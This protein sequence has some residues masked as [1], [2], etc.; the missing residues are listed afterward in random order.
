MHIQGRLKSVWANPCRPPWKPKFITSKSVLISSGSPAV[1]QLKANKQ[2]MTVGE[3]NPNKPNKIILFVGETGAGKSTLIDTLLNYTMGVKFEDEV[4]FQILEEEKR[5]QTESQTPDVIVYEIFDFENKTL[6]YSLT[7][8]DTPGY[9]DTR[10]IEH[11]KFINQRLLD[12]FRSEDGVHELHTVGL[13][14][15]ASDNRLSDRLMYVYDSVVSLFGENME[16]NIVAL[17]THSTGGP[18]ENVLHA[19][20]AA[21]VKCAKNEKQQPVHFLFDNCQHKPRNEETKDNLRCSWDLTEKGIGQF[22]RFLERSRHQRLMKTLKVLKK[23]I[24]LTACIQNLQERIKLTE[25]KQ[26]E[27]RQIQDALKKHDDEMKRNE[28]FTVEIDEVSK[29]KEAIDGGMWGVVFFEGAVCCTVCK[30]NCHYPGCTLAWK[31]EHCEVIKKGQCTSCTKKCP[32]SDHVKENWRYVTK[33]IKVQITKEEMKDKYDRNKSE[34]E[35]KSSL[36]E[37]LENEMENL[38]AEKKRLLDEAYKNVVKLELIALKVD[39]L[40]TIVHLDF[41]IE[42]VKE[43]RDTEKVQKLEEMRSR[44]DEG[45]RAKMMHLYQIFTSEEGKEAVN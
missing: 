25:L 33:T 11:D 2:E 14:M 1:Y 35:N 27:I 3:K 42:K 20:E 28:K 40:S 22:I 24:R 31:P 39:S 38:T 4:W 34:S 13:V 9:G 45:T 36:L 10:G 37:N 7:I 5:R 12:L 17:I 29:H 16:K 19:L 23:R 18:P 30:E 15:K 6:P 21:K 41:L 8:I 32:A 26:R 44:V 43:E